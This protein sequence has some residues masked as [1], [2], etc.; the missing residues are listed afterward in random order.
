MLLLHESFSQITPAAMIDKHQAYFSCLPDAE[1]QLPL[2][3]MLPICAHTCTHTWK[4]AVHYAGKQNSTHTHTCRQSKISSGLLVERTPL[5][6]IS[7]DTKERPVDAALV[8]VPE[9]TDNILGMSRKL[10]R[11]IMASQ[12]HFK[13][14]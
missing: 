13:R 7:P 9:H 10:R 6:F 5:N 12:L 2:V 11:P 3:H 14:G 1:V 8:K 4:P